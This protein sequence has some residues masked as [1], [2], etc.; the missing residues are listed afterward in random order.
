[1]YTFDGSIAPQPQES[2]ENYIKRLRTRLSMTQQQLAAAAGIHG[3]SLGKLERGKTL[4]LNQ[5]TKKGLAIALN[6]PEEYLDAVVSG[7]PVEG[8]QKKQYCP[9][10]WK[11]GTNPDPTWTMPK[12]KYC[13]L[14]GTQLRSGCVSCQEPIASFKHKFC[15]HCGTPYAE[16]NKSPLKKFK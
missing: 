8:V 10:C 2:L 3:Q 1:M 7:V 15:P 4:R 9:K 16:S 5:K 6:I 13:L 14:C 11:G 12:A